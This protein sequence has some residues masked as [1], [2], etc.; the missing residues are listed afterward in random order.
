MVSVDV[1]G[2]VSNYQLLKLT[3]HI[4]ASRNHDGCISNIKKSLPHGDKLV[5]SW[6]KL[7]KLYQIET[8]QTILLV[9]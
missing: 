5:A 9:C 7:L 6:V 4:G 8:N 3:S 2:L 1:N